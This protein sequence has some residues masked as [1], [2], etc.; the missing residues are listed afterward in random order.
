M[1]ATTTR[2]LLFFRMKGRSMAKTMNIEALA[3]LTSGLIKGSLIQIR[4]ASQDLSS[5]HENRFQ[6]A[7]Y[8]LKESGEYVDG[9]W[10]MLASGKARAALALSRWVLEA[11]LDLLWAVASRD[12][13]DQRLRDL[14]GE[15]LRQDA[16]LAENLITIWQD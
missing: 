16:I 14:C 8:L 12:E 11:A 10:E 6:T 15:A 1:A 3:E 9:A 2:L 7:L 4:G 5:G 13:T